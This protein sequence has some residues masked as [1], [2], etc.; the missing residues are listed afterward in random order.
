MEEDR[1]DLVNMGVN[2]IIMPEM[3]AGLRIGSEVLDLFNIKKE[4]ID[5]LVKRLRRQH[6]L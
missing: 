6:L 4:D 5:L 3:E 2:I 1:Y